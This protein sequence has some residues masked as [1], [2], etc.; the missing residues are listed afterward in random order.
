MHAPNTFSAWLLTSFWV[1]KRACTSCERWVHGV[2]GGRVRFPS[3]VIRNRERRRWKSILSLSKR[4]LKRQAYLLEG[5]HIGTEHGGNLL[6]CLLIKLGGRGPAV[7]RRHTQRLSPGYAPA[8]L[9]YV[10]GRRETPLP[11]L[12]LSL[13]HQRAASAWAGGRRE[14]PV[15]LCCQTSTRASPGGAKPQQQKKNTKISWR[16]SLAGTGSDLG[17]RVVHEGSL[18]ARA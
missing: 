9:Y 3:S 6:R 11:T 16:E 2:E 8:T 4:I 17:S 15:C 7:L 1:D 12:V 5:G 18:S 14:K 10:L 13:V